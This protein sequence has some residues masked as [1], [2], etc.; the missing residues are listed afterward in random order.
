[1]ATRTRRIVPAGIFA[2]IGKSGVRPRRSAVFWGVAYAYLV[3]MLGTTLPTPL[4]GLYQQRL[5]FSAGVLTV[6]FATYAAGVLIALVLFG[7][8]SDRIGRRPIL[9]AA[10][11]LA[12]V[13]TVVFLSIG[14]LALL[15]VGRLIS[16]LAAGLITSAATATLTEPEPQQDT[17]R[18][19]RVSTAASVF[20]LG[21]GP[22]LAG[23]LAQY[24]PLPVRLPFAVYLGLLVPAFGA[25]WVMPETVTARSPAPRW[26][27][28]RL[29]VSPQ[30]RSAFVVAAAAGFA[31]FAILGLF[32]SLAPTFVRREL[33]IGNLAVAGAIVF[34]VFGASSVSQL[35][36]HG[37]RDRVAIGIGLLALPLG[38]LLVVL[39]L[40]QRSLALFL[41]GAVVAGLGQG[42]VFM[43]G[44]ATINRLAPADQRAETI[45]SYF[46]VS[47]VAIS[48]PVI[49]VGFAAESFG[50]YDAALAFAVAIG[51]LALVTEAITFASPTRARLGRGLPCSDGWLAGHNLWR[52]C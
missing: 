14:D 31:G 42:L 48:V 13:S 28:Q 17:R 1:M 33:G 40:E 46:V 26:Q 49:G 41:S 6:I 25:V 23:V 11:V 2:P 44:L 32:T 20:G 5:G 47:Y 52:G 36:L 16:G 27:P 9:A 12:V 4:Y 34:V 15:F 50:L 24:G 30:V 51:A 8:L 10:L 7:A 38:L 3:T 22:V 29:A 37:L 21:L 39:A 18:A 43:G 35:L 45:S 19:S